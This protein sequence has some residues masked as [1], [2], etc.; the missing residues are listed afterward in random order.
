MSKVFPRYIFPH[1][2]KQQQWNEMKQQQQQQ[3]NCSNTWKMDSL[4]SF[5]HLSF[6]QFLI[7]TFLFDHCWSIMDDGEDGEET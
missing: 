4:L 6:V 5:T 1:G 3:Q 2:Y 7:S